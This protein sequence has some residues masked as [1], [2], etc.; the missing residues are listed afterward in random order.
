[1]L[2]ILQKAPDFQAP[3][4]VGGSYGQVRLSDY[5]GKWVLLFFYP[6]DFTFVC[7][8]E[9][10]ELSR[11]EPEIAALGTKVIAASCDSQFSH[12]AWIDAGLGELRFPL[13][14]DF[15]KKIATDYG[16]LLE[17]GF[18]ARATFVIDSEG[19]IQYA[20][21]NN[22]NVGRS[23]SEVIRVLEA[24]QTGAMT[25]VEW[26]RGDRTLGP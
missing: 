22:P 3:A 7:P 24:I 13:V 5:A 17:G 10:I 21:A 20:A 23:I 18:P 25:P 19:V 26:K 12:K 9:V 1:M 14:S 8:T 11:R 6:L 2:G 4:L 16:V 15:T